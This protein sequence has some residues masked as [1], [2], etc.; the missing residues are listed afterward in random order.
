MKN[1]FWLSLF[2]SFSAFATVVP[3]EN[4]KM[5]VEDE[6]FSYQWA[7]YNQSQIYVLEKDDI[8]NLP[9]TGVAGKDIGWG[10]LL[11]ALSQN[12]V[13]V[14]VLDSG[15]DLNHPEL[16]GNLWKNEKECGKD[17]KIDNDGNK[18][19]GDCNGWNF[20]EA[21]TTDEAKNPSDIDGHG[22]HIAGIIAAAHNGEGMVGVS[23]N[24]IIMP[25]K[26]LSDSSTSTQVPSSDAFARGI[27]YAVDNGA[28]IIN[29]SLGW[30]RSLETKALRDAVTYAIK[31]N[32]IIVAAAGNNNSFEPLFPCAYEGVVCVAAST[33]NGNYAG[34]S[35][36]G[37][38]VDVVAPGEGILGLNPTILEPEFFSVSGFEIRSGT[39][40]AAPIVAGL[41]ASVIARE[42]SITIDEALARVYS[43][44]KSQDHNKYINGGEANWSA[45]SRKVTT[46][47]VRPLLKLLRQVVV[48]GD[49]SSSKFN[50]PVKNFG[51]PSGAYS[52]K[53]ESLTPSI[54]VNNE[55]VSFDQLASG[56]VQQIPFS[57][58][59]VDADGEGSLKLK[60]TVA[61]QNGE[62]VYFNE[63]PVARDVTNEPSFLTIPFSFAKTPVPVG[64]VRNG[65]IVTSLNTIEAYVPSDKHE[66]V[67]RRTVKDGEKSKT[68]LTVIRRTNG[69]M[70]ELPQK[71]QVE[72]GVTTINFVRIDL[73]LDGKEDYFVHTLAQTGET[74]FF[75]F[76]FFD[77][78]L[79]PLW[80]SFQHIKLDI[81][82]YVKNMNDLVFVRKDNTALGKMMV[83][84]FFTEGMVPERNQSLTSWQRADRGVKD[85][86][87]YLNV[88][89][90]TFKIHALTTKIWEESI[91]AEL[92]SKWF[93]TVM[94]EQL[95]PVTDADAKKGIIRL[96]VSVG[97][98][99]KRDLFIHEVST[100]G[101]THGSKLPQIVIQT[102]NVDTLQT[103]SAQGLRPSGD[104]FLNIFDRTRGKII[105]TKGTAQAGELIYRHDAETDI[106]AGH[107]MTFENKGQ[108]TS[109]LQTREKLV[110]INHET[111]KKTERAKLRYS[112]LTQ[113]LLSELYY[114]IIY[115]RDGAQSPGLYVDSTS[116][117]GNRVY[118]FEEQNGKLV[119]SIRN[120]ILS[121]VNCRAMNPH[122]SAEAGASEFVFLCLIDN[123]DWVIR[124]LPMN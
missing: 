100:N 13:I 107:L 108:R 49:L 1:F 36:Y 5:L 95:L 53:V 80:S 12:R 90:N 35:N 121:P 79:N 123:K 104:V 59:V 89:N 26:V 67:V 3:P 46:P 17:P 93:D 2:L 102:D 72:N 77:E 31:K 37:G 33:L 39:S 28:Q 87:Y 24:A 55:V 84:A 76:S 86:L 122:Y 70:L 124:T 52:V 38:H 81:D 75:V 56:E 69:K 22:T 91:K 11:P 16:Q 62:S 51:T 85:R 57:V 64:G 21:L 29:M 73:N 44:A 65:E 105:V 92:K 82:V 32:V 117:T 112:F 54:H 6:L 8:H 48:R 23:P 40:Q 78:N 116:I 19:P 18:L 109:V 20:T 25:V 9:M 43:A 101:I 120:S 98:G 7:L 58:S 47:V 10:N 111:N 68:E 119:M 71:I 74:K 94:N 66:Y 83:P 96:M 30:P 27:I 60:I 115:K 118:L 41:L 113:K 15:V 34:F 50:L 97:L 106:L 110:T 99:T 88:E 45:L 103:V 63:V 61:D 4:A 42:G 114:P 14:A